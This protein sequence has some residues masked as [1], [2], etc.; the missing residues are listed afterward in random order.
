MRASRDLAPL[1]KLT[2]LGLDNTM[3][4]DAGLPQLAELE[5]LKA[6]GVPALDRSD[7]R[8]DGGGGQAAEAH[9]LDAALH[10]DHRSRDSPT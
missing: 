10:A 8:R 4:S 3:V 5:S 7:E 6:L 9:A 1:D 2:D